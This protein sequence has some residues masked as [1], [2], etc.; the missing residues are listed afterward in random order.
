M[1]IEARIKAANIKK[2]GS[3]FTTQS[4]ALLNPAESIVDGIGVGFPGFSVLGL[5][6]LAAH[7]VFKHQSK[8]NIHNANRTMDKFQEALVDTAKTWADADDQ[9][10]PTITY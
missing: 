3:D 9:S 4:H 6:L 2:L 10:K 5:P 8:E 7:E 1:S